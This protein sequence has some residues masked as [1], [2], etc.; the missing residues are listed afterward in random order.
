MVPL[1]ALAMQMA[2]VAPAG[3]SVSGRI[4]GMNEEAAINTRVAAVLVSENPHSSRD[5]LS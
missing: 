3:A 2:Q 4:L 5:P 1:L